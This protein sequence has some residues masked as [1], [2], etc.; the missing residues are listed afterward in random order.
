MARVKMK[1][2]VIGQVSVPTG[3]AS[4][5]A[6]LFSLTTDDQCLFPIVMVQADPGNSDEVYVGGTN[7][8][9]VADAAATKSLKLT[10]DSGLAF[11]ADDSAA[12]ED[13][14]LYDL[15]EISVRAPV[16]GQIIN[17][18]IGRMSEISYNK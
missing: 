17:V 15:R 2:E 13:R 9:G 6:A 1:Y 10:A 14:I 3:S 18:S 16:S 11:T 12:D 8:S 4:T 5:L 7:S